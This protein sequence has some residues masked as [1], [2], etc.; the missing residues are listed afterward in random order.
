MEWR[1]ANSIAVE[2]VGQLVNQR[3]ELS[4]FGFMGQPRVNALRLKRDVNWRRE[5]G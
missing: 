1:N 2:A 5:A 4:T 3:I